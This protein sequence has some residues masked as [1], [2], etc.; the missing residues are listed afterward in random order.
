MGDTANNRI[1]AFAPDGSVGSA[2]GIAG[3]GPGYVTR[4]RA[5]AFRPD[6][7]IAVADSFDHRIAGFAP[8]GTYDGETGRVSSITGF[9]YPGSETGQF[10]LPQGVAYGGDG[11]LW[12]ADTGNHRVVRIA[13]DGRVLATTADGALRVPRGLS[14][15]PDGSMLTTDGTNGLVSRVGLDGGVT[16]V[17]SG[18]DNPAALAVN[19]SGE[20]WVADDH[21]IT[22]V[23]SGATV[24]PPGPGQWDR[25]H[26]LAFAAD[27]TL[28]VSERRPGTP[29]GAR[30]LRGTPDGGGGYTWDVLAT[31]GDGDAQVI[32]PA[33]LALNAAGTT[34]L[35]ADTGNNRVLRFD[36]PG[37][38][39]PAKSRITVSVDQP[40]RGSVT[41]NLPGIAC[42]T[43]CTQAYGVGRTVILTAT[44]KPGSRLVGWTG[45]CAGAG[46]APVCTL[47]AAS[48]RIA[49]ARFEAI[50]AAPVVEALRLT[51]FTVAPNRLRPARKAN[52][53]N[54]VRARKPIKATVRIA[55]TRPTTLTVKVSVGK[56]G[57]RH[58]ADCR[59][60]T[61]QNRKRKRCTRFVAKAGAR[62]LPL[63][64]ARRF[65]LTTT[66]NRRQLPPGNY[67][68]SVTAVAADGTRLAPVTRAFR[69]VR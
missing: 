16:V 69:V 23:V 66:W 13:A 36:A 61:K 42:V 41:S 55:T 38:Q 52:A 4:P 53:R 68:L 29:D 49:G 30:L 15:L 56:S 35:V 6:G 14:P 58:G 60:P 44:P 54:R 22:N 48:A 67:R 5:V 12:V 20:A 59:V 45:D 17:R 51:R 32:E 65:T 40:A 43:D 2:W 57:R 28:Y 21:A 37:T 7:G 63:A 39:P 9:T 18:L 26:G 46:A 10:E 27:G 24:A 25:P 31:E 11:S 47:T 34:L 64:A 50:P 62:K 19:P 33:G 8:D 3:R 1:Q